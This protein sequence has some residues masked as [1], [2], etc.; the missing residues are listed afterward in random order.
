MQCIDAAYCYGC[1]TYRDL[2]VCE[3][4]T[5]MSCAKTAAPIEMPFWGL[6]HVGPSNHALDGILKPHGEKHF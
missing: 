1:R 5:R 6:T 2:C 3:S 4:V